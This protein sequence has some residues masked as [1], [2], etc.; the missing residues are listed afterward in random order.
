MIIGV[1]LTCHNRKEKTISCLESLI[2]SELTPD[3]I[4]KIYLVDDGSTDG[5]YNAVKRHFPD[6]NIINGTGDLYWNQGM[7]LAWKYSIKKDVPDFFIWLN[8][9]TFIYPFSL[10]HLFEC[11][12]ESLSSWS[13]EAIVV[14]A[15]RNSKGF[16]EYSYGLRRNKLKLIPNGH[17]QYGNLLNGNLVLI[18]RAIYE[19][20]GFLSNSYSH[21]FGDFDYGL[22]A[23]END[24]NLATT[25]IYVATCERNALSK[26]CDPEISFP[27]RWKNF[28]SKKGLNIKEYKVFKKRFW[29]KNYTASIFKAYLRLLLPGLYNKFLVNEK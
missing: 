5:T 23:L 21:S 24:F 19:R 22:R 14:G 6:V 20:L 28:H 17:I 7:R 25:K 10:K 18:S 9:D 16:D 2:S 13:K 15:C 29:P 26:W 8:D 1:L 4:L 3:Q 11:Y 27:A 12:Y